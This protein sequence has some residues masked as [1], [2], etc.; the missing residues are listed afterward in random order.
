MLKKHLKDALNAV[1]E[2]MLS[3]P[4]S[5]HGDECA[6]QDIETEP[7][8]EQTGT[9]SKAQQAGTV[10]AEADLRKMDIKAALQL[11]LYKAGP[12]TAR[13]CTASEIQRSASNL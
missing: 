10:E 1:K 13:R 12:R 3:S 9:P 8:Q 7:L 6:K 5:A 2:A 11:P 4:L